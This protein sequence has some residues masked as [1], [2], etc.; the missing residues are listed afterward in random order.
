MLISKN[1]VSCVPQILKLVVALVHSFNAERVHQKYHV[2]LQTCVVNLIKLLRHSTL[3][4]TAL[5][6]LTLLCMAPNRLFNHFIST[7]PTSFTYNRNLLL[8]IIN[9]LTKL[10]EPHNAQRNHMIFNVFF[11]FLLQRDSEIEENCCV[12]VSAAV[13]RNYFKKNLTFNCSF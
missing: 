12:R 7:L 10:V 13:I 8:G 11:Y 9:A 3:A 6:H 4:N 1:H 2:H 5:V